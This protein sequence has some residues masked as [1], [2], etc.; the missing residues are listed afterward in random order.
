MGEIRNLLLGAV[1]VSLA[2]CAH[3][4]GSP[5]AR[6]LTAALQAKL[7]GVALLANNSSTEPG[8]PHHAAWPRGVVLNSGSAKFTSKLRSLIAIFRRTKS[9]SADARQGSGEGG[10]G[11]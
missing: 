6:H 4:P 10:E 2:H 1:V 7:E 8:R 9:P 11:A 3:N 5:L